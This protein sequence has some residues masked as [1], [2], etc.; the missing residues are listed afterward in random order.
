VSPFT[1]IEQLAFVKYC[2][3]TSNKVPAPQR[4]LMCDVEYLC[5]KMLNE[6]VRELDTIK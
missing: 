4:N 3:V 1:F 5:N 2:K 6:M